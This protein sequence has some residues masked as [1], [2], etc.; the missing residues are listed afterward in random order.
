MPRSSSITPDLMAEVARRRA[1][2]EQ[3]KQIRHDFKARGLPAALSSY[4]RQGLAVVR[5]FEARPTLRNAN[6]LPS[7]DEAQ[8]NA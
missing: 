7:S 2:G 5:R 1:S 8:Q 4:H 6:A 3:W